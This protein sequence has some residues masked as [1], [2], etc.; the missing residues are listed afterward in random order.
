MLSANIKDE[1]VCISADSVNNEYFVDIFVPSTNRGRTFYHVAVG[2]FNEYKVSVI[3]EKIRNK[4][5]I[6]V[7][8]TIEQ[9]KNVDITFVYT[10]KGLTISTYLFSFYD[11]IS[12][13]GQLTATSDCGMKVLHE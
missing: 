10:K 3:P 4:Y 11:F 1:N 7:G 6:Q 2:G 9:L 13:D 12:M 8:G 5:G